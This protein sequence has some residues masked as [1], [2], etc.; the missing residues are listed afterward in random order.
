MRKAAIYSAVLHVTVVLIAYFGL[1][2]LFRSAPV[3]NQPVP[4]D[5]VMERK[6]DPPPKVK[7]APPPPRKKPAPAPVTPKVEMPPPPPPQVARLEAVPK[8]EAEPEP[9]PKPKPK[10]KAKPKPKPKPKASAKPVPKPKPKPK[11]PPDRFQKLLKNLAK[12]KRKQD[13]A[14]E[15]PPEEPRKKVVVAEPAPR[16][17]PLEQRRLAATIALLVKQQISA[18]WSIPGGAKDVGNMNI[19]IRILLNPD[20]TLRGAPRIQDRARMTSDPYFRAVAESA[21]RALRNPLCSPLRLPFG[22]YDVWKEIILTF[23]P[24]EALG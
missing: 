10:P 9:K 2:T 17:T 14:N 11:P 15:K 12:Q 23:N 16:L 13:R 7:P 4:V 18:C 19:E 1:P 5:L 8:P 24:R 6:P 3:P 21:L 22:E 20:G